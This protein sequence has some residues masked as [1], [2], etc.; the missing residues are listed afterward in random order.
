MLQ[1]V[2]KDS[3]RTRRV[4][5][6]SQVLPMPDQAPAARSETCARLCLTQQPGEPS[7]SASLSASGGP[8]SGYLPVKSPDLT[9]IGQ[10]RW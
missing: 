1:E 2:Q 6:L 9:Q 8:C 4:T 7:S 10:E 3:V 5:V